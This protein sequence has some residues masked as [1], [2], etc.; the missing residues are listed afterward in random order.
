MVW[1]HSW[2]LEHYGLILILF[3]T[4]AVLLCYFAD[5]FELW[6]A[7]SFLKKNRV[8]LGRNASLLLS[9]SLSK[10]SVTH[11]APLRCTRARTWNPKVILGIVP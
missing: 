10:G 4:V 6:D 8:W 2:F 1:N 3:Q 11:T 9:G 7:L 5:C